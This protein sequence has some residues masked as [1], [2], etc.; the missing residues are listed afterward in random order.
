M[1][2]KRASTGE[3]TKVTLLEGGADIAYA[4][5]TSYTETRDRAVRQRKYLGEEGHDN[6]SSFNGVSLSATFPEISKVLLDAIDLYDQQVYARSPRDLA[7]SV[8]RRFPETGESETTLFIDVAI[9]DTSRTATPGADNTITINFNT[10][11]P[12][13]R[14]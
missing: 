13:A 14:S 6:E 4:L 8:T 10:G 1:S 11:K 5:P 9:V 12:P 7:L 2:S 3:T